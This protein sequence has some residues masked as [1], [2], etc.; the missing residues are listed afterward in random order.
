MRKCGCIAHLVTLHR[1]KISMLQHKKNH[2]FI[3]HK[4]GVFSKNMCSEMDVL[5]I[6]LNNKSR[7]ISCS[8]NPQHC[9]LQKF[10]HFL[11]WC[12]ILS[13]QVYLVISEFACITPLCV[14]EIAPLLWAYS[15]SSSKLSLIPLCRPQSNMWFVALLIFKWKTLEL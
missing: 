7:S 2:Q 8:K 9:P 15:Q 12:H 6:N 5:E 14:R 11:Y 1:S 10:I 13:R 4:Y 3:I